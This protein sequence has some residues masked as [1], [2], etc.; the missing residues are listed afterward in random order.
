MNE[1]E[2]AGNSFGDR[3]KGCIYGQAIGDA[4]GLGS[5]GMTDE[6][7]ACYYPNGLHHYSEIV[8]D[9]HR[10][11]W[12]RGDW[13]DD[14]DMMLCI[15]HAVIEDKGVNPH[16]HRTALQVVGQRHADG[17]RQQHVQGAQHR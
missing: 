17:H 5:E 15:A 12:I 8:Q 4:L 10:K 3:L 2:T 14:T 7:M 6:D 1:K 13:T 16:Q 9:R 11:R